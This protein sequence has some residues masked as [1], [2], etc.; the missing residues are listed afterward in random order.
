MIYLLSF[1]IFWFAC[2][3]VAAGFEYSFH[4]TEWPHRSAID[5][6]YDKRFAWLAVA[7]GVFALASVAL[8]RKYRHGW[9][10]WW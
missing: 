1:L 10:K 7:N 9:R 5:L 4:Q 6:V 2:G 8:L 3:A